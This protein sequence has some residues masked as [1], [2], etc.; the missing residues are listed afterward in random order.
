MENVVK[1]TDISAVL[2][3]NGRRNLALKADYDPV[4]GTGC[5]GPRTERMVRGV[6]YLVPAVMAQR[7]PQSTFDDAGRFRKARLRYDFEYWCVMCVKIRDK[8]TGRDIPFVLNR[9]QRRLLAVMENQRTAGEPVR[10]ILLKAR[11]WGGSTLVQMYM[12]WIQMMLHKNWN[13]LICGHLRD[14]SSAI[15]GIYS[16]LLRNYPAEFTDNGKQMSFKGFE[17]SKN[18]SEITGRGCVVLMGSA[19]MQESVRGFDISMAHLTEVAFWPETERHNP[20]DV[21]RSVCGAIPMKQDSVVVYESTA[22]GMGNFF[23]TEWLRSRAGESDKTAV[24]VPWHEIEIYRRKVADAKTL[25]DEMDDYERD[26]WFKQGCTLEM[27]NWYHHKRREYQSHSQMMAEFPSNDIEAFNTT[28]RMV[29]DIGRLTEFAK[30][31]REPAE[32]G[33]IAADYK[34]LTNIRWVPAKNGLMQMWRKPEASNVRHRWVVT[35]DVGGRSES[36][37]FSV[38][39]VIDRGECLGDKAEVVAQWRGHI[40]HDLLAW[41]AAQTARFYSNAL[42]VVES[43]TLECEMTEGDSSEFVLAVLARKYHH[44]YHRPQS[45]RPGFQTNRETKQAAISTLIEYVRDGLYVERDREAVNEMSWYEVKQ[46]GGYGA[47][48]GKHDD[49]LMTRAIGLTVVRELN[50]ARLRAHLQ[51]LRIENLIC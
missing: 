42:L 5:H 39:S 4:T 9:A 23:H 24:F 3:E 50:E 38:I 26:L 35:V 49:I 27:I 48:R 1:E 30:T 40:D 14:T 21:V 31:C 20:E 15:K 6:R 2:A 46:N 11:Q 22:N 36:S 18:V 33:D 17:G 37:D 25:W 10:V 13:S 43:N 32:V 16:R 41:K 45:G 34:S 19:Q 44:I 29:F 47:K 51:G 12:A 28:G 8:V 7:E